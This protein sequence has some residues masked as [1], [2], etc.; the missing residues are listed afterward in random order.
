MAF[1]DAQAAPIGVFPG[2]GENLTL[3]VPLSEHQHNRFQKTAAR[4]W[5]I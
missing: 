1:L 2:F 4:A 3:V 5:Q